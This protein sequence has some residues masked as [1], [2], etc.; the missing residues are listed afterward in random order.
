ML[1]PCRAAQPSDGFWRDPVCGPETVRVAF[2]RLRNGAACRRPRICAAGARHGRYGRTLDV[3]RRGGRN[4][5]GH[6]MGLRGGVGRRNLGELVCAWGVL[7]WAGENGNFYAQSRGE[8]RYLAW[9]LTPTGG[10]TISPP[11]I[12]DVCQVLVAMIGDGRVSRA[13]KGA[14][15]KSAGLAF[16]G[17]SPTSPTNLRAFRRFV[18]HASLR[19]EGC[20]PKPWCLSLGEGGLTRLAFA[21]VAQW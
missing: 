19:C 5:G 9:R 17:S 20:P 14:D 12:S 6:E 10:A 11:E 18:W 16:V 3:Q 21:G 1:R 15:C 13:A 4:P 7:S 2:R 8:Y